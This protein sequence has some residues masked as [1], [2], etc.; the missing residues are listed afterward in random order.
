MVSCGLG[1]RKASPCGVLQFVCKERFCFLIS[2]SNCVLAAASLISQ[3]QGRMEDTNCVF[4]NYIP[5]TF[6]FFDVAPKSIRYQRCLNFSYK[7]KL[8]CF[9]WSLVY[10]WQQKN[11]TGEKR[12]SWRWEFFV[13]RCYMLK[14]YAFVLRQYLLNKYLFKSLLRVKSSA[15]HWWLRCQ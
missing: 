11:L 10:L 2:L 8:R 12:F 7:G 3:K 14:W 15:R 5:C 9:Q 6:F 4:S 1:F 13:V